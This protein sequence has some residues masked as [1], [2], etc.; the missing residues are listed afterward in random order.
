[1][2]TIA[3]YL[4]LSSTLAY[5]GYAQQ[6]VADPKG[7]NTSG[8]QNIQPGLTV[9]Q[10][11]NKVNF[12]AVIATPREAFPSYGDGGFLKRFEQQLFNNGNGFNLVNGEF[13]APVQGIYMFNFN[14]ALS[15]YGCMYNVVTY[16]IDVMK[17]RNQLVEGYN[18]PVA[19]GG[20]VTNQ[21]F[22]LFVA[23]NKNETISLKPHASTCDHGQNPTI[24][25]ITFSGY[26][27]D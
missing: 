8:Q 19:W 21:E 26:K 14:V 17:N 12:S 22:T 10:Q 13:T 27:I 4:L 7:I 16:G 3:I 24:R 25:K 20:T 2:K 15:G 9:I 23:L 5:A 18:L 11:V 1:M 6:K